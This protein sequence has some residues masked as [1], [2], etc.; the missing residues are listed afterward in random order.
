MSYTVDPATYEN[1]W[2]I[3]LNEICTA[4]IVIIFY[5]IYIV[6]FLFAIHLLRHRLTPGRRTLIALT[7]VMALLSTTQFVLHATTVGLSLRLLQ[8]AIKDG[9]RLFP[10]TAFEK[11]YLAL[12]L[13]QDVVLVTNTVVTD[14]LF[15]YRC[16]LVWGRPRK[17]FVIVPTL[18]VLATIATGY[19]TSYDEDYSTGPYHFDPRI[20]FVLNLATNFALMV[21]IA[22]RIWWI[23]RE[24]RLA[25][26]AD[27]KPRYNAAI[28][29]ILESGAIYCCGLIFQVIGLSVQNTFAPTVYLSHG[30]ITQLVNIA[31]TLIVVRV[32]LGHSVHP[33]TETTA[34][35]SRLRISVRRPLGYNASV[36]SGD[37]DGEGEGDE[38]FRA[39]YET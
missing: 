10:I 24:Q 2:E 15:V 11:S 25:F 19:V 12:V 5:G 18:L 32:G 37:V 13:A 14:G 3:V 26:G 21:L 7:I 17:V 38:D 31:P 35:V 28:A 36:T 23:M 29:I 8:V 4:S 39:W 30:A 33:T 34:P 20:V 16:Y 6:L 9:Q 27:F 1:Y 22:G